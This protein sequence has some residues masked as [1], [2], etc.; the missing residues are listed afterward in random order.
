MDVASHH[1]EAW[2]LYPQLSAAD[3][4]AAKQAGVEAMH[5]QLLANRGLH[6]PEEMNAFLQ[7]RYDQTPDPNA[8]ID[9]PLAVE[10]IQ[11]ALQEKEHITV[12]GDYDADG[13]TSSSL[14]FRALR[15]L[16]DHE[17]ILDFH[18]PHR[19]NDGCGLNLAALDQ[20]KARG[21]S[22]II[23]TDC[24]SSDVEQVEY[25]KTL[26]IDVII[27]DHHHPPAQRPQAYAM[28]NPWRPDCTYGER[29]LCGVGIAFKL[30]QALYRA[31]K[32][33]QQEELDLLDLVA[34]GTVADIAPLLGENHTL[35]RL[36][37]HYLNRTQKPGLQALI[38]KANLQPGRI[39]ERDIAFGIAPRINAAGRMQTASLAFELMITD[40]VDEANA[41]ADQLDGLNIL[42]QHQTEELTRNVREQSLAQSDKTII[43][44]SGEHWH[45]GIIGLVAGKLAEEINKPVLV[46][47]QDPRTQLSRGS[48]RS[49]KDFNIIEALRGF[50]NQLVRYGG[51][52]Q[53]AGFTIRTELTE[54]LHEHLLSW[55]EH[56]GPLA[57]AVIEGTSLPD[58][59]GV[60]T[61]QT[62]TPAES[63]NSE[64]IVPTNQL[65]MVDLLFT[66]M[67]LLSY[68]QYK[69]LRQ[70][71]P[72][73]A[74]NPEPTFKLEKVKLLDK[75][76]SGMTKQNLT[77]RL[78]SLDGKFQHKGTYLRG[79][80]ELPKL[81][82]ASYV[83]VIFRLESSEDD[84][85]PEIWL[86]ILDVEPIRG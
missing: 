5:A 75:W 76:L 62:G 82:G 79:A 70:L 42:R 23:T 81:N 31:Y 35:V 45:E 3:F 52:A 19:Q 83:N 63:E 29:Y 13:V 84:S 53:A 80:A 36:G 56:G 59:T 68:A 26:G 86:K 27:T 48:A 33:T 11:R 51:H 55:K 61:D 54:Q 57:P 10:R 38:R 58:Q 47:S 74:G 2:E 9:M 24:A 39:K 22:L 28:V 6:T 32:R 12:Y 64:E 34:I 73:G 16:K 14:L 7:A 71:S 17:A 8:L 60:V 20:L 65:K 66:R 25:A 85:R 4:A 43:L 30:T 37:M 46:L 49:Q 77:M 40:D 21:T 1:S 50:A 44:A 78:S 67:E 69:N 18:I 15:T 72:F 41:L